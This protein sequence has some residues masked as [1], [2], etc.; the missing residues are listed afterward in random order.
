[1]NF[2]KKNNRF[3]SLKTDTSTTTPTSTSTST[4]TS[5]FKT[6]KHTY[7]Q[8]QQRLRPSQ[9]Q[10]HPRP[11]QSST[12]QQLFTHKQ[13]STSSLNIKKK[14]K[15]DIADES[16]PSLNTYSSPTQPTPQQPT[17]QQPTPP[18]FKDI[19]KKKKQEQDET[20]KPSFNGSAYP[21]KV[22]TKENCIM[23]DHP[24]ATKKSWYDKLRYRKLNT[25][26]QQDIRRMIR[27]NRELDNIYGDTT[28]FNYY[29]TFGTQ[30]MSKTNIKLDSDTNNHMNH[31]DEEDY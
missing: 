6:N 23:N 15:F 31:H 9:K 17:P 29:K 4:S 27:V 26:I 13:S 22:L 19:T 2:L 1:M 8:R 20:T 12:R 28:P 10:P 24:N 3:D 30:F 18:L 14:P 21:M 16:F 11:Q 5:T 25:C 7:S